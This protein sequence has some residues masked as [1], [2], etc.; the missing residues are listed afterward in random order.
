MRNAAAPLLLVA[1]LCG[2]GWAQHESGGAGGAGGAPGRG[3]DLLAAHCLRCHGAERQKGDVDLRGLGEPGSVAEGE[4]LRLVREVVAFGD[5]PPE[6]EPQPTGEQRAALLAFVDATLASADGAAHAEQMRL[7]QSG[8]LVDHEALFAGAAGPSRAATPARRWL[9]SPQIFHERVMDVFRLEG[10]DREGMR[11]RAFDGVT[12]PFVLPDRSGVRDYDLEALDGG[13]F[14][15][16]RGNVA[17]IADRQIRIARALGGE[18]PV[19]DDP[20]DR[21][22]PRA[23]PPSYEAFRAVLEFG[24]VPSE[25]LCAAAVVEQFDCAF[26]RQ[27]TLDEIG[28]YTALLREAAGIGGSEAGLRQMLCAV[29]LESEFVYRLEFGVGEPDEHGRRPLAPREAAE[30]LSYALGDRRPDQELV[31]AAAEG[32]LATATDFEREVLRLLESRYHEGQIDP[33]L[34][35]KHYSSNVTSHPKLIRFFR[36]FFGYPGATKVFKDPPRSGGIYRNPERGTLATPGRLILETDRIVT[37]IVEADRDVFRELLTSDE[38]FVYHDRSNEE[39]LRIL[40]EWRSVYERLKESPWRTEPEAVLAEHLEFLKGVPAMRIQD[41]SRPGELVNY[42]HFFD[43]SFGQGRRPFTTVPWAHGYTFHHAPLYNLPPTPSIG[44]Y[45]SWKSTQYTGDKI[46]REQFWDYE[47]EQPLR[48]EHRK[49]VLTHPSWLVAHSTNFF[50]DPVRRGR[51]IREKLLAGRVPDVPITV[52]AQVPEDPART[53]R[54]RLEEVTGAASC[55]RCHRHMN[56]LGLAF[57]CFDDFG[58]FRTEE[59][60]EHPDNLISR[61]NGKT[62]FDVYPTAPVVTTGHLSGT[63]EPSLDGDVEDAFELID[64]LSRSERVR[65]S[66][67]RHAFRFF[68]GRN[69]TLDDAPTLVAA[70]RAYVDSGGSFRAVVVAILSSD[71]FRYRRAPDRKS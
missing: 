70:D 65:Q 41:A 51:F 1:L 68:L 13:D 16:M 71:S 49:G 15:V 12:N 45:G 29:L 22:M 30:A 27:P 33:S 28:R 59:E 63:G 17:W 34:N 24:G 48:L 37:R 4:L 31:A 57:E 23:L 62:T 60:L 40:E 54:Q 9:V 61:G 2:A 43:E 38:F 56:P 44:R 14:L 19:F 67:I 20:K 6:D 42:M 21:W 18:K 66:M 7:P 8:N 52:D 39:G 11:Y 35:G 47:P 64:R 10:R 36:E 50:P 25:A 58:R 53:Y 32:R 55:W 26:R 5:M 69:E 3:P 46:E